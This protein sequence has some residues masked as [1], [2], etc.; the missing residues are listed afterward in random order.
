MKKCKKLNES[1]AVAL[2]YG[3]IAALM[4]LVMIPALQSLSNSTDGLYGD[5]G[6]KIGNAMSAANSGR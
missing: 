4:V 5:V 3:L 6:N 1:G 2:E